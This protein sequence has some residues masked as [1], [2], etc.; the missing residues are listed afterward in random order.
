MTRSGNSMVWPTAP[1]NIAY[2]GVKIGG[3]SSHSP[4]VKSRNG[5]L[6]VPSALSASAVVVPAATARWIAASM[7]SALARACRMER[8]YS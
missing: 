4:A 5:M 7:P 1:R 2:I 8:S 6:A 3:Q